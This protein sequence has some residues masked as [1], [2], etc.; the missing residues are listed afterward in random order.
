[1]KICNSSNLL[2]NSDHS[3]KE[4]SSISSKSRQNCNIIILIHSDRELDDVNDKKNRYEQEFREN[5]EKKFQLLKREIEQLQ[6][7]RQKLL[8]EV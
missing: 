8:S 1:M 2:K 5:M 3:F 6:H 7:E 4:C